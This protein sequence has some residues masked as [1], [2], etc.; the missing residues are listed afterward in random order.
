MEYPSAKSRL[1]EKAFKAKAKTYDVDDERFVNMDP[2]DLYQ[3]RKDAP[4]R[5]RLVRRGE[6]EE[7]E[8][9]EDDEEEDDV[10]EF[11]QLCIAAREVG[12]EQICSCPNRVCSSPTT[13]AMGDATGGKGQGASSS[14]ANANAASVIK[15]FWG[16]F[17]Y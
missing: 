6:D 4:D 2:D 7:D 17:S 16:R 15:W 1:L 13:T 12:P 10:G 11:S 14:A 8:D 3:A 9:E 5:R